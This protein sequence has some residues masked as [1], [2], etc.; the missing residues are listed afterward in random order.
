ME[1]QDI[2]DCKARLNTL[3]RMIGRFLEILNPKKIVLRQLKL[4][5]L[6]K[7]EHYK[8]VKDMFNCLKPVRLAVKA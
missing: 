8:N 7:E 1:L 4:G 2:W 5:N 6:R 3:Q